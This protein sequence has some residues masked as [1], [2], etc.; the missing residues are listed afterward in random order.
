MKVLFKVVS[1]TTASLE[2]VVRLVPVVP[3]PKGPAERLVV[4]AQRG[5]ALNLV[6]YDP[7]QWGK[8]RPDMVVGVEVT[9]T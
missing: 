3:D 9:A 2:E 5:S 8:H 4:Q 7:Q 1:V 6:I